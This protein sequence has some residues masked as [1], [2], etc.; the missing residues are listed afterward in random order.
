MNDLQIYSAT[1]GH[2]TDLANS[3]EHR[4]R[5]AWMWWRLA[6]KEA[7]AELCV[8]SS[9]LNSLTWLVTQKPTGWWSWSP[10]ESY[11]E[12]TLTQ[13]FLPHNSEWQPTII[14]NTFCWCP[15]ASVVL[16]WDQGLPTLPGWSWTFRLKPSSYLCLLRSCDWGMHHCTQLWDPEMLS[17]SKFT[18]MEK[19]KIKPGFCS[20]LPLLSSSPHNTFFLLSA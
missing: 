17:M 18:K 10:D 7:V 12:L 19:G 3:M 15:D 9:L 1:L 8:F 14:Q 20:W 13:Q 11:G 6:W 2:Q 5:R 16:S 4:L